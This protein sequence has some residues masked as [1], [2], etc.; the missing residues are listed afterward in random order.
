M[1]CFCSVS[2]NFL[3]RQIQGSAE[4]IH[5]AFMTAEDRVSA[6]T[7]LTVHVDFRSHF[8]LMF[9]SANWTIPNN[10]LTDRSEERR[11]GLE[12]VSTCKSRWSPYHNKKKNIK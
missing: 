4:G 8:G 7:A 6:I 1:S 3:N 12:C 2:S 11:G 10:I 5:G 9:H